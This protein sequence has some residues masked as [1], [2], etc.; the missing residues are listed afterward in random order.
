MRSSGAVADHDEVQ[1]G[2]KG[3]QTAWQGVCGGM[4]VLLL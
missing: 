2:D 4:S 1:K 3:G